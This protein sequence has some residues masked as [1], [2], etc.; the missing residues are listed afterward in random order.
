MDSARG[1]AITLEYVLG[2]AIASILIVGLVTT[3][4]SFVDQQGKQAAQAELRVIGQQLA[5]DIEAVDRLASSAEKN[6]TVRIERELP[7][8]AAGGY[9]VRVLERANPRLNLSSDSHDVSV[10]IEFSNST[11]VSGTALSGGQVLINYTASDELRVE[12]GDDQ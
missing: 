10:R 1:Q 11:A 5:A 9:T 12:R 8:E 3:G 4:A 6:T 2:V 7:R